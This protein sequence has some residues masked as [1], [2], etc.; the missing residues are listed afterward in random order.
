MAL[1]TLTDE[2]RTAALEKAAEARKVRA[3]FKKQVSSRELPAVKALNKALS[4]DVLGK[5]KVEQFFRALPTIGAAKA[6]ALLT[7]L[8]IAETR[9]LRGLGKTQL[10]EVTALCQRIDK[11]QTAPAT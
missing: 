3:E 11:D 4:D 2:Q 10:A 1:P 5:L 8:D 9:R 7:Q 6:K